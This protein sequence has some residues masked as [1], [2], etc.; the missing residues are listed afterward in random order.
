MQ[1]DFGL[2]VKVYTSD[3][4]VAVLDGLTLDL[5][6][7]VKKNATKVDMEKLMTC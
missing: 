1:A 6:G 5:A 4:W 2:K 7:K 3:K